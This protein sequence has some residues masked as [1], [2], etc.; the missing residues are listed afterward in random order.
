MALGIAGI[1]IV[2]IALIVLWVVVSIPVYIAARVVTSERPRKASFG[3]AMGATL[4]GAIVYAIVLVGA[5]FF[6]SFL[7]GPAAVI[8]A[9][10]LAVIAWLAVYRSV[11]GVGWLGAL[12]IAILA[13]IVLIIINVIL[14]ALLGV[15]LPSFFHPF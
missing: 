5:S 1:F 6:L 12:G 8:L 2:L 15:Q 7:L 13:A 14:V 4:G 3:Q 11:F 9:L 10:L